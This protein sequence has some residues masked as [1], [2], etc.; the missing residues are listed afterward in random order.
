MTANIPP[1]A[2]Y[3]TTDAGL[4]RWVSSVNSAL[5][6]LREAGLITEDD[7]NEL[8]RRAN[9]S[10]SMSTRAK[11]EDV[12]VGA[13]GVIPIGDMVGKLLANQQFKDAI[14]GTQTAIAATTGQPDSSVYFTLEQSVSDAST[15]A[16]AA[17][18]MA[19]KALMALERVKATTRG[20]IRSTG[21]A[22]AWNDT[23]AAQ[24]IYWMQLNGG[25]GGPPTF[26]TD[27]NAYLVVGDIVSM[28]NQPTGPSSWS[29][30]KQWLGAGIGWASTPNSVGFND[31][32]NLPT[33]LTNVN[34]VIDS[35]LRLIKTTP[36]AGG[37][38]KLATGATVTDPTLAQIILQFDFDTAG[39]QAYNT[40]QT[41][42]DL[43]VRMASV[44][45]K[46]LAHGWT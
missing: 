20:P 3:S 8:I 15:Q 40:L 19:E 44:E 6:A 45:A 17:K 4:S 25:A 13:G 5:K 16:R 29:E 18:D 1:V 36:V 21:V 7:L 32:V 2:D 12:T 30:S 35:S 11:A 42:V 27:I 14:G 33:L 34:A 31:V 28:R 39:T 43:S 24:C 23:T 41:L 37:N 10:V 38:L 22:A 9:A 26:P 46:Q